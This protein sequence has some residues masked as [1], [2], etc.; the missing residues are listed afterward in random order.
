[1]KIMCELMLTAQNKNSNVL[2][3]GNDIQKKGGQN[4]L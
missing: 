4:V 1:M 2:R 3:H